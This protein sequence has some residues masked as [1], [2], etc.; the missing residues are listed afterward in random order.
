VF[1]NFLLGLEDRKTRGKTG[2][3]KRK[4]RKPEEKKHLPLPVG[5]PLPPEGL[6]NQNVDLFPT[7][8]IPFFV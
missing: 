6:L 3:E 4:Q 2:K 5:Q 7:D 8:G 1:S